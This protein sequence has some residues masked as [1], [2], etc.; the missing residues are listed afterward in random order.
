MALERFIGI[1]LAW[2][3]GGARARPNETGVAVIDGRGE[4]LDCDWTRGIDETAEWIASVATERASCLAFVDAPLV[5][6]NPS[7]Q[8]PCEREVGRRYGRWK[9]SANSTN[10]AS[11][12]LAGV[13]L[14][15][16]LRAAGWRYDDGLGGP[17]DDGGA[18][19]ECYPYTTLVGAP[20]LGYPL[21]RPPYKRRPASVPTAQ[22]RAVRAEVCDE[23]I[24]RLAGLATADP[25][26]RLA[27]HPVARALLDEPTPEAA[28]AYK[29][30]EDLIDALLCAWTASLWARHG[31]TRCQVLGPGESDV[32]HPGDGVATIIAPARP[33]Q[34]RD[35]AGR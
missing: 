18:L 31:L 4:V 33:E 29:H 6:D 3:H 10:T 23:L 26:L 28:G 20:E 15:E 13:L 14:L 22:W 27:S 5:V 9:V 21:R 12:R 7:G 16:R 8:R 17:P 25:P 19:S 32:R 2:A 30:R 24:A 35:A 11:P 34:R 1:D